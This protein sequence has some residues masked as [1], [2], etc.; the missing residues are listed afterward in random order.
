MVVHFA[1]LRFVGESKEQPW[2]YYHNNL[3]GSLTLFKVRYTL[4][5]LH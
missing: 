4:Q 5:H 3:T 2:T 1:G